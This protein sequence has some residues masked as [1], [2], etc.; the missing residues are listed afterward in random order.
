MAQATR[1]SARGSLFWRELAHSGNLTGSTGA[2]S[3]ET[4]NMDLHALDNRP[5]TESVHALDSASG[6]EGDGA[7]D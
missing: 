2:A 5:R 4:P 6:F 1:P 3:Q 7:V